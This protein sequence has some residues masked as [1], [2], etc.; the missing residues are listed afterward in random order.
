MGDA[1]I[2]TGSI[3]TA[4]ALVTAL[5]QS[6]FERKRRLRLEARDRAERRVSQAQQVSGWLGADEAAPGTA[7]VRT[8]LH[9]IN[10]SDEPVYGLVVSIVFIQGA[11][12]RCIEDMLELVLKADSWESRP[13]TTVAVL[14][15]GRWRVWLDGGGHTNIMSGRGSVEIA[16]T[17]RA[18][19]SW[20]R[21]AMGPIE[22]IATAPTDYFEAQGLRGPFEW[23]KV[24]SDD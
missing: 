6:A 20:I 12:P 22:E 8:P 4:L 15:P 2:W 10:G 1:A 16:F 11:A 5:A 21:R 3:V 17:D 7:E 14:P 9:L 18:G 19:L 23:Q 24:E 13:F